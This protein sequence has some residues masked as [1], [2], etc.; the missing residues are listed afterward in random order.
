[1]SNTANMNNSDHSKPR[2][3]FMERISPDMLDALF[4]VQIEFIVFIQSIGSSIEEDSTR[5]LVAKM[6]SPAKMFCQWNLDLSTG[7]MKL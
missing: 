5:E 6:F 3:L 2:L 7:R 1:M 4:P